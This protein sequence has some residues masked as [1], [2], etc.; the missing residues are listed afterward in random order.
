MCTLPCPICTSSM[1]YT[2]EYICTY[3][4]CTS[5]MTYT[6]LY[7]CT[8]YL[9][10]LHLTHDLYYTVC[11]YPVLYPI[12]TSPMTYIILYICTLYHTLSVPHPWPILYCI[13]V[14]YTIP[15]LYPTWGF[16]H[17][18]WFHNVDADAGEVFEYFGRDGSRAWQ[19]RVTAVEAQ[20]L[21][22]V[23]ENQAVS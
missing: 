16:A 8:L 22:Y 11:L 9:P 15:C 4:I 7:I 20:L 14:P 19:Q 17:S 6:I 23:L 3:P 2:I 12:C 21:Q 13:S 18:K 5:H 1:T 10:Y